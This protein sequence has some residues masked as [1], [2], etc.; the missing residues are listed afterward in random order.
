MIPPAVVAILWKWF[1]DPGNG[2]FNQVLSGVGLPTS[3]WTNS[4]HTAIVSLVLV[5]T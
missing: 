5:A 2:L 1:Y 3:A 4:T